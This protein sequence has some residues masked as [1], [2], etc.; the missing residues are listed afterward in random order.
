MVELIKKEFEHEYEAPREMT[1]ERERHMAMKMIKTIE[2]M[3]F[4][5]GESEKMIKALYI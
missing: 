4:P 1:E 5:A 2:K 3:D